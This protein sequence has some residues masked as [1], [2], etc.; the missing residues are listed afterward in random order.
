MI[1]TCPKCQFTA[2][3]KKDPQPGS[4]IRCLKCNFVWPY[5]PHGIRTHP[6]VQL[7]TAPERT[8]PT[9]SQKSS[10][11]AAVSS[12]QSR[13]PSRTWHTMLGTWVFG[14]LLFAFFVGV[15]VLGPETLPD[16]KQRMLGIS[17]GLLAGLFTYFLTGE[18]VLHLPVVGNLVGAKSRATGGV[19][20]FILVMFWWS[21]P[22]RP[23]D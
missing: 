12:P 23:S 6:P 7:P 18:L 1:I 22:H 4:K 21:S 11:Q 9:I 17:C 14:A 5:K 16:F 19:G 10:T 15:F 20:L 3:T 2:N 8:G 13:H